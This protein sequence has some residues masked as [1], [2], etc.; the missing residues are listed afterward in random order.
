MLNPKRIRPVTLIIWLLIALIYPVIRLLT[1][2]GDA[3]LAA[4]DAATVAGLALVLIGVLYIPVLKGDFDISE[5][6]VMRI[7]MRHE[8]KIKSFEAFKSDK[9]AEREGSFNYPLV[10]GILM[11]AVSL[12]IAKVV[13]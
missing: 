1:A 5:Y 4:T 7:R 3:L 2:E 13:Y 11:L 8:E 10:I 9:E 6:N 12:I